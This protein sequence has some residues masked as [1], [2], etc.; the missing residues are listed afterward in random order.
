MS[1]D[2]APESIVDAG[3]FTGPMPLGSLFKILEIPC[4]Y[5]D[6]VGIL[7]PGNEIAEMAWFSSHDQHKLPPTGGEILRFHKGKDLI[8]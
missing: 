8:D 1:V 5:A 3:F 7:A 4:F 2:L 6:Y